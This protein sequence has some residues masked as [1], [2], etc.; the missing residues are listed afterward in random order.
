MARL[1]MSPSPTRANRAP[2][3]LE[4]ARYRV[5][6]VWRSL[7][8]RPLDDDDRAI[9]ATTL[10]EAGRKLFAT[11]TLN[12]QR[13][14]LTVYRA[15]RERHCEDPDLLA[16]ALLHDSGKGSGRVPF[17]ARPAVVLLRAFAPR[18]LAWL[19]RTPRQWFRRPFYYAIHHAGIGADL[20]A[21]AGLSERAVT[22]IRTHHQPDGPAAA[23]HA[24]DDE[25]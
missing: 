4:A 19:A 18:A 23:L 14:S 12:D 7:A 17:I 2:N 1:D 24:V 22:L 21:R 20:A 8:A 15:L 11:M 3:A 9:L 6:Q 5:Y 25:V 16:A 10:P 13:H